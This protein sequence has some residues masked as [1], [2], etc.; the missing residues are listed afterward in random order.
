MWLALPDLNNLWIITSEGRPTLYDMTSYGGPVHRRIPNFSYFSQVRRVARTLDPSRALATAP[1]YVSNPHFPYN[2]EHT[3]PTPRSL[4]KIRPVHREVAKFE[5]GE[6]QG[7]DAMTQHLSRE[8]SEAPAIVPAVPGSAFSST[9]R[10][11]ARGGPQLFAQK[12]FTLVEEEDPEI[13]EWLPDGL[14]FRV[15][16]IARFS[17]EVLEKYF[18]RECVRLQSLVWWLFPQCFR[19]FM[20]NSTLV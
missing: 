10:V 2:L 12:L 20:G 9:R 19:T 5:N 1:H 4:A 6:Q 14:A 15:K 8:M 3:P 7:A 18:N 13:V 16:D 11:G 17:T